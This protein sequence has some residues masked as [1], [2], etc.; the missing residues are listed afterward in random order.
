[1]TASSGRRHISISISE[2]QS[3]SLSLTLLLCGCYPFAPFVCLQENNW[4]LFIIVVSAFGCPFVFPTS[5]NPYP[6]SYTLLRL[7]SQLL[8]PLPHFCSSDKTVF[9]QWKMLF[10]IRNSH[11]VG[12][13][14]Q[15]YNII[16]YFINQNQTSLSHSLCS[17]IIGKYFYL[18]FSLGQKWAGDLE[19]ITNEFNMWKYFLLILCRI[20]WVTQ[21]VLDK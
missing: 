1:V 18:E 15:T 10:D 13:P 12:S 21:Q 19:N 4:K 5:S 8:H 14:I 2:S 20:T 17:H 6:H 11:D 9:R 7:L 3:H 16:L